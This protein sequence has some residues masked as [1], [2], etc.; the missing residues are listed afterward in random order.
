M[1]PIPSPATAPT[2]TMPPSG[3]RIGEAKGRAPLPATVVTPPARPVTTGFV[4][5][6]ST[7]IVGERTDKA[8]IFR[9]PDGTKTARLHAAPVRWKDAKGAWRDLDL[10]VVPTLTGLVAAGTPM[11][12]KLA[13]LANDAA[14]VS[15]T[16]GPAR[17][18]FALDGAAPAIATTNGNRV[19]YA[20]AVP[21]GDLVYTVLGEALKEEIVLKARPGG[22]A[23]WR[24]PLALEGLTPRVEADG[25]ISFYDSGDK[26]RFFVPPG[27]AVDASGDRATNGKVEIRLV[28]GPGS[29]ALVVTPEA[30]WLASPA[31]KFPCA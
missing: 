16:N 3:P 14:L 2:A 8:T 10:N 7:E 9:N 30:S 27:A 26:L 18:G 17:L 25:V 13:L 23:S 6:R 11:A 29:W 22:A 1:P 19:T 4:E 5:G 12:P 24:F 20:G 28:G 15:V 21:D 31:R